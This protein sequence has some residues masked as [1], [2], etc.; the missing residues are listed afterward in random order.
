[1]V[2]QLDDLKLDP[3]SQ[4]N[5]TNFKDFRNE[6]LLLLELLNLAYVVSVDEREIPEG[7]TPEQHLRDK[8][9]VYISL[10][11]NIHK[12]G[13]S[14]IYDP[15]RDGAHAW[16]KFVQCF[17]P[18]DAATAEE[19]DR[20]QDHS[21]DTVRLLGDWQALKWDGEDLESFTTFIGRWEES[22]HQLRQ[23][24]IEYPD[25]VLACTL[26]GKVPSSLFFPP[27]DIKLDKPREMQVT[28]VIRHIQ[29]SI[30][31]GNLCFGQYCSR[32]PGQS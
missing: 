24:G 28:T 5:G 1:M 19:R 20:Q 3:S 12:T 14:I 9:L 18:R 8:R 21:D 7:L 6:F 22:V 13:R 4:F 26:V 2:Q 17:R 30:T 31:L 29:K 23:R 27:N 16:N 25:W 10:W 32:V 11:L 15:A